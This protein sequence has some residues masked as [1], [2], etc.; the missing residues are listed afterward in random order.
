M[1]SDTDSSMPMSVV[2]CSSAVKVQ[3]RAGPAISDT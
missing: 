1:T 3:R 2:D